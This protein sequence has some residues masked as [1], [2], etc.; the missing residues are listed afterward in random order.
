MH[1]FMGLPINNLEG[2]W[3]LYQFSKIIVVGSPLVAVTSPFVGSWS[4]SHDQA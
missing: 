2:S 3:I 4:G 1:L